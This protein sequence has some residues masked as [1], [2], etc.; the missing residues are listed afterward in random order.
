MKML[1]WIIGRV[2][3]RLIDSP[4]YS[5]ERSA[6]SFDAT[7]KKLRRI[8]IVSNRIVDESFHGQYKS[9]FRGQGIEFDEV[10]EYVDGDDAR[11]IDW[12][13]TARAAKPYVKRYAE[14]RERT[15]LIMLDLSASNLFGANVSRLE[16]ATEI[17]ASLMFSAIKN[18][19]KVGLLTFANGVRDFY[20][21]KKGRKYALRLIKAM[22][23]SEP[24]YTP[25]DLDA[26]LEF[27]NRTM[28]RRAIVF[29]LSDFYVNSL[30][31]PLRICKRRH[32]LIGISII[33]P[34]ENALPDL[35]FVTLQDPET[36][37]YLDVDSG[38]ARFRKAIGARLKARRDSIAVKF[39]EMKVDLITIENG[40]D[41]VV[42]LRN[43]FRKRER[44]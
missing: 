8:E 19:D 38:C 6:S 5:D 41:Y 40:G 7:L 18:N 12:N 14:E 3:A 25:T 16:S 33:E 42:P 32:D 1:N 4:S 35:G 9:A 10:R 11:S 20:P 30:G 37:E 43:F 24:E 28:R 23:Q 2:R 17:A 36:G 34:V 13:V 21:P 29:V 27:V 31:K 44:R 15:L 39:K 26:A 22:L